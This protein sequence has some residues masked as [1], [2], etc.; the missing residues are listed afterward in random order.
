[1]IVK[2]KKAASKGGGFFY[3]INLSISVCVQLSFRI[4]LS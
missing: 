4:L 3:A 1:M 2:N